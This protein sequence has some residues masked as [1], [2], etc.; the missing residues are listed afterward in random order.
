MRGRS[1]DQG[2]E[3][4]DHPI[5]N[6]DGRR[7]EDRSPPNRRCDPT[8]S[9]LFNIYRTF[10]LRAPLRLSWPTLYRQFGVDPAKAS[11]K[12]TVQNFRSEVLQELVKIKLAWP[13]LNY[14]TAKSLLIQGNAQNRANLYAKPFASHETAVELVL[15]V[16]EDVVPPDR[17]DM[18]Q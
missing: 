8:E 14:S 4:H 6:P 18:G 7:T 5:E 10:P 17:A 2:I 9:G 15:A 16:E 13:K 11:D 3:P 1:P 12:R